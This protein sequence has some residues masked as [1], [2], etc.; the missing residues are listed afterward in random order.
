MSSLKHP[1]F[2]PYA[3]W[4]GTW[5]D[6]APPS[7][8]VLA[9]WVDAAALA[10]P[11]GRSLRVVAAAGKRSALEHE[12]AIAHDASIAVRAGCWHDALNVLAW[13]L[14]PRTKAALT[15]CH[16][17]EGVSA[18]ANA[19]S[20]RRDAATLLDECGLLLACD[21]PELAALLQAHAWH[22]L[23]VERAAEVQR[24][25]SACVVGHGLLDKLRRP[26]RSLTAKT[27]ILPVA[28]GTLPSPLDARSW[29]SMAAAVVAGA[30]FNVNPLTPLPVAALPGWDSEGMGVALFND[31]TVFRPLPH[32]RQR[33]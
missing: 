32:G 26:Y 15:A 7:L 23:F 20:R 24:H 6:E 12:Q 28:A 27:L 9:R 18:T 30:A 4:L 1:A 8:P 2:V 17:S 33:G 16:V 5:R 31:A 19:R 11:D 21:A 22:A 13:L 3:C 14:L 25:F 29:D 10:M